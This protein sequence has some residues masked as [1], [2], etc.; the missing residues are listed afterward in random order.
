MINLF[1]RFGEDT[2]LN[3]YGISRCINFSAKKCLSNVYLLP[4]SNQKLETIS[5]SLCLQNALHYL[6]KGALQIA[7]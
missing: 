6:C 3:T 7:L 5:E 4:D 1:L 2:K